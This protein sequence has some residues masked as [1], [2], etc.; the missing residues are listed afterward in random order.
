MSIMLVE[1]FSR[2]RAREIINHLKSGGCV[3][4]VS[5]DPIA[6]ITALEMSLSEHN[7]NS[8][9]FEIEKLSE[10]GP[11]LIHNGKVRL[12]KSKGV[13]FISGVGSC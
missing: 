13:V 5:I 6:V 4:A 2:E 12:R 3:L 7:E 9:G 11:Y 8:G 1:E 10:G